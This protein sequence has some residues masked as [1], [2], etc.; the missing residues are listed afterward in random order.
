ME[1]WVYVVIGVLFVLSLWLAIVG[2]REQDMVD[3]EEPTTASDG[4]TESVVVDPEPGQ[5]MNTRSEE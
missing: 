5:T 1:P 4:P 3:E 2:D